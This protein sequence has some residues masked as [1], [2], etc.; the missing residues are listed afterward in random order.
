MTGKIRNRAQRRYMLRLSVA[1]VIYLVSLFAADYLI[2]RNLVEGPLAWA[3]AI[4]PGLAI[5][6]VFVALALLM[7][8]EDDEFLRML[9]V[10]QTLVATGLAL[11]AATIWGFLENFGLVG[12]L[13]AYWW[14]VIWF[15]GLGVGGLVNKLTMGAWGQCW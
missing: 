1:M 10:R 14:A 9:I 7:V 6:G 4:L 11:S 12:H 15:F 8:E 3:L 13:D 2:D 5:V